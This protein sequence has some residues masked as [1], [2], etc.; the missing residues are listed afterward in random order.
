MNVIDILAD[1]AEDVAVAVSRV[2]GSAMPN[3]IDLET[4]QGENILVAKDGSL[5][6][7]IRIHGMG[8][9]MGP[10]EF[11]HACSAL[12]RCLAPAMTQSGHTIQFFFRRDHEAVAHRL[13]SAIEPS[14]RT[15]RK[16]RLDMEDILDA[17]VSHLSRYCADEECLLVI[18][19]SL[20]ALTS[21]EMKRATQDKT[22]AMKNVR[23]PVGTQNL[24]A[25]W[26]E[27]IDRHESLQQSLLTELESA[28]ILRESLSAH[29]MLKALRMALDPEFTPWDWRAILPGDPVPRMPRRPEPDISEIMYPPIAWQV[30]PRDLV[31]QGTQRV[32]VGDRIYHPLTMDIGPTEITDFQ[33]L[34]DRL[35][36]NKVP[37]MISFLI[38][39]DGIREVSFKE[40]MAKLLNFAS[41]YNRMIDKSVDAMREAAREGEAVVSL[42]V[43]ACTWGST[44]AEVRSRAS[45]MA[46]AM[47]S[48][49]GMEI[50]EV[51]GDPVA[52]LISC[53][54]FASGKSVG[55]VSAPP[56]RDVIHMLPLGRSASPW[57]AG[58]NMFRTMDGKPMPFQPGSS[59]QTTWNY[60][61]FA[62][63]GMGKS[64]LLSSLMSGSATQSGIERLPR[65][66]IIDIGPSSKGLIDMIRDAL[67]ED[68]KHLAMHFRMRMTDD[69]IVNPCDTQL[70]CRHPISEEKAFLVNFLTLLATPPELK[71]SYESMSQ[72]VSKVIDEMYRSASDGDRGR[73][74][75]YTR[76]MCIPVDDCLLA[77]KYPVDR[78]TTWW[79]IVDQLFAKGHTHEAAMAQ[80]YA[81]PTIADAAAASRSPSINDLYGGVKVS[82][83]EPLNESFSRMISDAVRDYPVLSGATRF[84]IGDV[85]VAAIDIDEVAKSGGDQADRQTAVMYM[86]ARF[87]LAKNYKMSKEV[88]GDIPP[89]YR[90]FHDRRIM[91]TREDMKWLCYD[92]FHRTSSSPAVRNQ[93]IVDM[94]E[95]RKWNLGIILASQSVNDFDGGIIDFVSGAF[96]LNGGTQA[97]VDGLQRLFGFNDTARNLLTS[98]CHGPRPDGAPF[99]AILQT[100]ERSGQVVQLLMNT[101]SPIESW[102]FSSTML[103]VLLRER[104]CAALG[105]ARGRAALAARYPSGS[106]M[107]DI[108]RMK[109]SAGNG[110]DQAGG[111]IENL[112]AEIVQE[113]S[114][115]TK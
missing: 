100:R 63:P 9:T 35:R 64:V 40:S 76:G 55:E 19:T 32:S 38:R 61:M 39:G 58:G 96:I 91:E 78:E 2:T 53:L 85:R 93:V 36:E 74:R 31:R 24:M 27:V 49:G 106:A 73:P 97:N 28:H 87:I 5:V 30:V 13:S 62:S 20:N 108:N 41:P 12:Y 77:M 89:A 104:V 47:M 52:G 29:D 48:W 37:Y 71:A 22:A 21:K 10:E 51:T 25:A 101:V 98:Y 103:D 6:S 7:G 84:D 42:K 110:D 107:A 56:L 111:I 114:K 59:L 70:G 1:I 18:R 69:Y 26:P 81:V 83:G 95:G 46:R 57:K 92:E 112:A 82:T 17:K 90:A 105:S 68:Q 54:P 99:L 65:I 45:R 113:V 15:V 43:S 75:L 66:S 102:A 79:E 109:E 44:E 23:L 16:L 86:L 115:S 80:R 94:R 34:F 11:E 4:A 72:L 33:R 50:A 3:Y 88:L 8:K 60:I 67:P 14:R